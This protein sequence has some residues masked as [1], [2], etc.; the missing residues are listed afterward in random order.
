MANN[1]VYSVSG[2]FKK[3]PLDD[4]NGMVKYKKLVVREADNIEFTDAKNKKQKPNHCDFI[5]YIRV[6]DI[7]YFINTTQLKD[8]EP[9]NILI[10]QNETIFKTIVN[11]SSNVLEY[12]EPIENFDIIIDYIKGYNISNNLE[13]LRYEIFK[14]K[15]INSD[16]CYKKFNDIITR[17]KSLITKLKMFKLL[18]KVNDMY[19]TIH[20]D[21]ETFI[22]S[23]KYLECKEPNNTLLDSCVSIGEFDSERY[24]FRDLHIFKT[25]F[26]N[27]II[28][29]TS[30]TELVT[31]MNEFK[32]NIITCQNDKLK[33]LKIC[34]DIKYYN[35]HNLINLLS[36]TV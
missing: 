36:K 26:Y 11:K 33:Y 21:N 31:Q 23:V 9:D 34:D 22:I 7:V 25:Y 14:N 19:R 17:L 13:S 35:F 12:L 24:I 1:M 29:Y 18:I 27:Y 5:G 3:K 30:V 20:I 28:G 16:I 15:S 4:Y 6:N 32:K 10:N 2:T 8:L